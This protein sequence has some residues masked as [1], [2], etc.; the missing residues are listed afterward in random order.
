MRPHFLHAA[1]GADAMEIITVKDLTKTFPYSVKEKGLK[2]S[3]HNLF[4]RQTLR[5]TASA[6]P[7]NRAK[8]W[9]CLAPTAPARPPR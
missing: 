7:L 2:G 9:A 1:T 4:A 8:R 5:S 3:L 6:L